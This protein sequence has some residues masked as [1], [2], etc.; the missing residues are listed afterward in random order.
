MKV[1]V[2]GASGRIGRAIT[3]LA[4]ARGHQV[5][6]IDRAPLSVPPPQGSE[7][8]LADMDDYEALVA[9]FS[10]CDAVIHM[11]AIPEP[12]LAPDHVVHNNNVAG[13]YNA[14]RAAAE[15]GILRV[16]QAS[17]VNAIGHTFS[18]AP[19]YDYFPLD[20]H[21]ATYCD[22]P[23]SLS[24]WICE[25]QGEAFARRYA[26]MTI[27]SLR[28]H[29]VVPD[30]EAAIA[31][32]RTKADPARHLWAWTQLDSAADACLLSLDADFS[33]H[34]AFFIVAPETLH[35]TPT[36]DLAAAHF[37]GVELR[38]PLVGRQSFFNST[39][40]ERVLGWLHPAP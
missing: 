31:W 27:A 9:G 33:G 19:R 26:G 34:E 18:L 22:D 5:V 39:K 2:T 4:L 8:V 14:L 17:S 13:S 30:K 24:K 23:Y 32:Y 25:A 20:E 28:F 3:R 10:G 29:M 36:A 37:P 12:G 40:A 16:C 11:A 35:E 7:F 38:S 21:H 15:N 6:L 1:A